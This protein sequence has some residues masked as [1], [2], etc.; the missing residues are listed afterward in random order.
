MIEHT[1]HL[2]C[3][4][5]TTTSIGYAGD[6]QRCPWCNASGW[7]PGRICKCGLANPPEHSYTRPRPTRRKASPTFK[8]QQDGLLDRDPL[9]DQQED[10]DRPVID[11]TDTSLPWL[12]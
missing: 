2:P 3:S 9:A 8:P 11:H 12:A 4:H 1:L 6:S 7:R 5:R 10:D